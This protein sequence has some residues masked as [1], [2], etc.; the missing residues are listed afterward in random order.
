MYNSTY[1]PRDDPLSVTNASLIF[2]LRSDLDSRIPTFL[3]A[4][5]SF[6]VRENEPNVSQSFYFTVVK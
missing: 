2:T 5:I 1:T 3:N 4:P 6:F